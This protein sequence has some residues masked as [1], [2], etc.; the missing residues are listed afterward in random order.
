MLQVSLAFIFL[1]NSHAAFSYE[2]PK[3]YNFFK[4]YSAY[5]KPADNTKKWIIKGDL[6]GDKKPD[7]VFIVYTKKNKFPVPSSIKVIEIS[8]GKLA[9][10]TFRIQ[11]NNAIALFVIHDNKQKYLIYDSEKISFMESMNHMEIGVL[12]LSASKEVMSEL[13]IKPK[14]D[15]LIL[16]NEAGIDTY[17]YW[18]GNTYQFVEPEEI[19]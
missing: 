19:P 2:E 16:P 15:I 14:G 13:N 12:P 5:I 10:S 8:T 7:T 3:D 18:D 9:P 17:L 4:Q 1:I 11:K 6:N